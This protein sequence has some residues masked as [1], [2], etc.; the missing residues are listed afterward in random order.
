MALPDPWKQDGNPIESGQAHVFPVRREGDGPLHALKRLKNPDRA[1]RFEREIRVMQELHEAGLAVPEVIE[2]GTDQ[3]GKPYFVMPWF[4]AGALAEQIDAGRFA[5]EL[6]AGLKLLVQLA[7]ILAEL[8]ARARAHRDIKPQN[9]LL[10]SGDPILTDFGLS[11]SATEDDPETRL[12]QEREGIG[13]RLYIAPENEGGFNEEIDQRPADCYAF[14]KLAWAVLAGRQPPAREDQELPE[15]QLAALHRNTDLEPLDTLFSDLIKPD[16][17]VRLGDWEVVVDGLGR[18]LTKLAGGPP[19]VPADGDLV[20]QAR[21]AARRVR[22]SDTATESRRAE[23]DRERRIGMRGELR[24]ALSQAIHTR[25]QDL[26][27]IS[28]E[29]APFLRIQAG[30][31]PEITTKEQLMS[32][33]LPSPPELVVDHLTSADLREGSPAA[34]EIVDGTNDE[35]ISAI[36]LGLHP[37]IIEDR[38]WIVRGVQATKQ[39]GYAAMQLTTVGPEYG[40]WRGPMQL[41]LATTTEAAAEFATE[42]I[43][44]GIRLFQFCADQLAAGLKLSDPEVWGMQ[45]WLPGPADT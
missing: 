7:E 14:G 36:H 24:Q 38:V 26:S 3:S 4:E 8:H 30:G 17:R 11:L 37:I 39:M 45:L 13:S 23:E 29:S 10:D 15:N 27:D 32:F 9:V 16:P 19:A 44:A 35:E 42:T 2:Q 31:S 12:T 34:I 43:E 18:A 6:E 40:G 5:D 28:N 22:T 21:A 25:D 41:G 33:G 1:P 20:D